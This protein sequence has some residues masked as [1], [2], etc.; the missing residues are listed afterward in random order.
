M[1]FLRSLLV[2]LPALGVSYARTH[3]NSP[4]IPAPPP[5]S[6][7]EHVVTSVATGEALPPLNTTYYFN[8]LIDHTNPSLGTFKQR[9]WH[10][11]EWYEAGMQCSDIYL[12]IYRR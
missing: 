11:W 12:P 7:P 8:Q 9:F 10:T 5:I 2:L 1:V 4:K 6:A 3:L